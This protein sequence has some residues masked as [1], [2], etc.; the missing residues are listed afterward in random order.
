MAGD[1]SMVSRNNLNRLGF[2]VMCSTLVFNISNIARV[3]ISSSIGDNLGAAIRKNSA[4]FSRGGISV[5][6]LVL[7]KV[8][9]RVAVGNSIVVG[10][11]GGCVR[12]GHCS[13]C[14]MIGC[15][16]VGGSSQ[17]QVAEGK[18]D[19]KLQLLL[20]SRSTFC[21]NGFHC[22]LFTLPS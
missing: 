22:Y 1:L 19:L 20:S 21:G 18:E 9:S 4:V 14:W 17:S 16:D 5:P 13:W 2:W 11:D 8:G 12:V 10:I 7:S 6:L 3:G 15:W